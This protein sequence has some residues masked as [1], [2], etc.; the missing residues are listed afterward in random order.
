MRIIYL[1]WS[2]ATLNSRHAGHYV[3]FKIYH[4]HYKEWLHDACEAFKTVNDIIISKRI[5]TL[6]VTYNTLNDNCVLHIC[7][8]SIYTYCFHYW[9]L[10]TT[11]L[12]HM[13]VD[14]S[15]NHLLTHTILTLT[16]YLVLIYNSK[17]IRKR[18]TL[19]TIF[20]VWCTKYERIH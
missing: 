12:V 15:Y 14:A 9:A 16:M 2:S 10:V 13:I 20:T 7:I 8:T 4:K 19:N 11:T 3:Y 6:Y 17:N 18:T 1:F 5:I